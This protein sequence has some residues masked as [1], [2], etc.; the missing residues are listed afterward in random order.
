MGESFKLHS[1]A[2]SGYEDADAMM[3][4]QANDGSP[5]ALPAPQASAIAA[6]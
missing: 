6:Y 4:E 5:S 2:L 1:H 3:V